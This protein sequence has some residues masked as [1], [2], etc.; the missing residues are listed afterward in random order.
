MVQRALKRTVA[1]VLAATA[2]LWA[3]SA[4]GAQAQTRNYVYVYDALGRL[5]KV[6]RPDGSTVTYTYD[7]AGNRTSATSTAA[8][9][10]ETGPTRWVVL[11]LG[12]MPVIPVHPPL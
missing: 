6:T 11:P 10:P 4:A 12:G 9:Y 1:L 5:S 3:L 8:L 2:A 7:A